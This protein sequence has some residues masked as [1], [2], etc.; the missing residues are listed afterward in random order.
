KEIR[1]IE[2]AGADWIHVDV[3][4]GHFVPNITIGLGVVK[5]L[6]KVSRIPI[7]S[8]LMITNPDI[9]AAQFCDAGSDFV[10]IHVETECDHGKI[11]ADIRKRG[12]KCGIVLN[13]P[14]GAEEVVRFI[15]DID[16]LLVMSVN[17]G[18]YGQKFIPGVLDKISFLKDKINSLNPSCLLQVDGGIDQGN[19]AEVISRGADVLVAGAA[20]FKKPDY[21]EA[22]EGLKRFC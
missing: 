2:E 22:V 3:M 5:D 12:K 6:R 8:H 17:P 7:D 4:D 19:A 9:Y 13:P 20:V 1:K 16:Y 10:S 15:P 14:T 18:F 21:G 11:L